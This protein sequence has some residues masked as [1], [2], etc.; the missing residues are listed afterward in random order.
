MPTKT[1]T[2][3]NTMPLGLNADATA[4]WHELLPRLEHLNLLAPQHLD[5]F[6]IRSETY[7]TW[8]ESL[9]KIQVTGYL[10][11]AKG[12][13]IPFPW[14][15]WLEI[16]DGTPQRMME[17]GCVLGF[18]PTYSV[19]TQLPTFEEFSRSIGT[20]DEMNATD[21][22]AKSSDDYEVVGADGEVLSVDAVLG[23]EV[24]EFEREP[25]VFGPSSSGA[26]EWVVAEGNASGIAHGGEL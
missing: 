24:D 14:L 11:K 23:A 17:S 8:R 22:D 18:D 12:T 25:E 9:R 20:W 2:S 5:L 16:R 1:V 7:G 13:I 26:G 3:G 10:V 6:G 21:F 15:A 19:P 4:K